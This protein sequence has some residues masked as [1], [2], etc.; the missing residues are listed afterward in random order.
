MKQTI[1]KVRKSG[2]EGHMILTVP[3]SSELQIGD[4]VI[5]QRIELNNEV[6]VPS[7]K[8]TQPSP[9]QNDKGR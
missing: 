1:S 7:A 6:T 9:L 8:I 4:F 3:K 2:K 5:L